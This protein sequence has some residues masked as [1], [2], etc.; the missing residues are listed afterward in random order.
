MGERA[1][2]CCSGATERPTTTHNV[3]E[4]QQDKEDKEETGRQAGDPKQRGPLIVAKNIR[5]SSV[6]AARNVTP[7]LLLLRAQK[8]SLLCCRCFSLR[9]TVAFSSRPYYC[10][11]TDDDD[12][13]DQD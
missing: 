12:D 6:L 1:Q 9:C 13:D 7:G 4:Q 11:K 5:P 8:S 10:L 3:D 2:S